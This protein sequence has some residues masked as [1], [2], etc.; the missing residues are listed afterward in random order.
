MK[1]HQGNKITA[2]DTIFLKRVAREYEAGEEAKK[3]KETMQS[4]QGDMY[5]HRTLMCH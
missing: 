5:A 3:E 2:D 4:K 1:S